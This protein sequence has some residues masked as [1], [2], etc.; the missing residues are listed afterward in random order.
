MPP[1]EHPSSAIR[2][3]ARRGWV[4]SSLG[5]RRRFAL[6]GSLLMCAAADSEAQ[7]ADRACKRKGGGCATPLATVRPMRTATLCVAWEFHEMEVWNSGPLRGNGRGMPPKEHPSSAVRPRG[8]E[9]L[10]SGAAVR[11]SNPLSYGRVAIPLGLHWSPA[12]SIIAGLVRIIPH[13]AGPVTPREDGE[14][15]SL[16]QRSCS[17]RSQPAQRCQTARR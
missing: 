14:P 7:A 8:L 17:Y 13:A 6:L 12:D 4:P 10:A 9:P 5:G 15:S 2:P 1:K 16:R 11:R 3:A